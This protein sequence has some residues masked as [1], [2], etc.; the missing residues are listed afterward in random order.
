[1]QDMNRSLQRHLSLML[2]MAI[3][4]A[5]LAAT[6]GSFILAYGEAKE[7]QD[8]TLRQIAVLSAKM[9]RRTH[10]EAPATAPSTIRN[11]AS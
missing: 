5:G 4:L 10:P 2:G 3:V 8:D 11:H 7:F 9:G 6:V 1:M